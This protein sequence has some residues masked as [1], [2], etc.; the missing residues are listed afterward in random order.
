MRLDTFEHCLDRYGGDLAK[1]PAELRAEAEALVASDAAA[2][3]LLA[4]AQRLGNLLADAALPLPLDSATL[5]R[6]IA[7]TS[8]GSYRDITVRPTGR[9]IGWA[10]AAM[11]VWLVAGFAIGLVVPQNSGEDAI[12]G[13]VFGSSDNATGTDSIEGLL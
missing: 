10:S 7:A 9:L 4:Q 6:I 1:W 8:S 13:L 2:A 11:M 12:A 3:R 5:G